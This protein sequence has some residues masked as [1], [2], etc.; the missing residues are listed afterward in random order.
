MGGGP[1]AF[2][3]PTLTHCWVDTSHRFSGVW[4]QQE[5]LSFIWTRGLWKWLRIKLL[6]AQTRCN[7][8][9]DTL[10][11]RGRLICVVWRHGLALLL[12]GLLWSVPH[13]VA[14]RSAAAIGGAVEHRILFNSNGE[15][16]T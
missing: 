16:N 15:K 10:C 11:L 9:R 7:E 5:R 3:L 13:D 2:D 4:V 8:K 14:P 6:K 1:S 12:Y